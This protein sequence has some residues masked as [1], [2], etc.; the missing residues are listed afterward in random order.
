[1]AL[2]IHCICVTGKLFTAVRQAVAVPPILQYKYKTTQIQKFRM[3][4]VHPIHCMCRTVEMLL[5]S[6]YRNTDAITEILKYNASV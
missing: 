2:A 5:Q 3:L 1:M 6:K 4:E